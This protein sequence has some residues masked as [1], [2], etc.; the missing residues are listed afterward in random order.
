MTE[1]E[2]IDDLDKIAAANPTKHMGWKFWN[3]QGMTGVF[4]DEWMGWDREHKLNFIR[5]LVKLGVKLGN[6]EGQGR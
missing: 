4:G 5:G 6:P 3:G 1:E 2:A